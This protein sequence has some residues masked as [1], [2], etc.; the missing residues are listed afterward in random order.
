MTNGNQSTRIERE[1]QAW[2]EEK[3]PRLGSK[4]NVYCEGAQARSIRRWNVVAIEESNKIEE[5]KKKRGDTRT[6]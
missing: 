1:C 5:R 2:D 3:M 6:E 4:V